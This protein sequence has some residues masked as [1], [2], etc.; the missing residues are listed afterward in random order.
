MHWNCKPGEMPMV[1]EVVGPMGE[2]TSSVLINGHV[3]KLPCIV[4]V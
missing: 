3:V 2:S 1:A 4:G